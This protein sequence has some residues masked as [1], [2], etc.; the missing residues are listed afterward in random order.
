M[1]IS[2]LAAAA[3]LF[4]AAASAQ[5]MNAEQFH[6]RATALQ[7]KGM[8]ALFSSDVKLLMAEDIPAEVLHSKDQHKIVPP[9][10]GA[11][12]KNEQDVHLFE[13]LIAMSRMNR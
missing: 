11:L 8:L 9:L 1:R 10:H 3:F 7:K 13:R 4:P 6:Q 2:Y 12:L 5:T